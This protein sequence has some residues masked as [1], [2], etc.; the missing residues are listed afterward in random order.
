MTRSGGDAV[1]PNILVTSLPNLITLARLLAVP[2]MV[3]LIG[4]GE[5][6]I[7]FWL[8]VL[9]GISDAL[10]GFIAKRFHAESVLGSYLD[11]IADKALLVCTYVTLGLA[12]HIVAWLVILV[13]FRDILIVGGALLSSLVDRPL[14]MRPIFVSKLNTV[15]QI[16][17]AA[18]VLGTL[19]LGVD[20]FGATLLFEY[21]VAV[22]TVLSGT[23]YLVQW[24][25]GSGEFLER[26]GPGQQAPKEGDTTAEERRRKA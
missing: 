24:L 5:F 10:D 9:A 6:T 15:A 3:W 17:L 20:D 12:G 23:G 25:T 18:L 16:L 19:G 7:A 21:L 11:P 1:T 2:L 22:T 4:E 13:V 8:F 26:G 14:R